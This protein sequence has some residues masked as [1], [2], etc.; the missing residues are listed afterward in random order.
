MSTDVPT[1][2][3]GI[4]RT[5]LCEECRREIVANV[6]SVKGQHE[7]IHEAREADEGWMSA[8]GGSVV[9]RFK[10]ECAS[11]DV[12]YGPGSVSTWKMPDAWMWE[13]DDE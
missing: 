7:L 9:V 6:E 12:E 8:T 3:D 4:P 10:C 11:V 5:D 1:T 13:D 2:D